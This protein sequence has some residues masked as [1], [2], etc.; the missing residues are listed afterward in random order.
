MHHL[1][2]LP[3]PMVRGDAE[4]A[5]HVGHRRGVPGTDGL[6]EGMGFFKHEA[7][8]GHR[9]SVP[10]TDGLVEEFGIVKHEPHVRHR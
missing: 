9:R 5:A 4:H 1:P 7:H 2:K 10:G 8:V 6:V 3:A